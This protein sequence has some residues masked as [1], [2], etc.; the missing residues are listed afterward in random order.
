MQCPQMRRAA[1][2]TLD[3]L[4]PPQLSAN[5]T[6]PVCLMIAPTSLSM[7]LGLSTLLPHVCLRRAGYTP[8]CPHPFFVFCCVDAWQRPFERAKVC[9]SPVLNSACPHERPSSHI[10]GKDDFFSEHF[11]GRQTRNTFLD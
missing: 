10:I 8:V 5:N 6:T 7:Y 9:R 11:T 1:V 3:H 2:R 4:I